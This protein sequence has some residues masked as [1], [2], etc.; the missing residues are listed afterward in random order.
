VTF[1]GRA[2]TTARL[3]YIADIEHDPDAPPGLVEF[4]RA[5][6]FRSIFAAPLLRDGRAIGAIG[7]THRAVEGFTPKQGALLETFADQAVIAI[8]NVRLFTELQEKNSA[9]TQAHAQITET[10]EQQ[11]ATADILRVIASSPTDL[12]PVFKAIIE[13]AT[14][15]CGARVGHLFR[16]D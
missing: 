14:R 11:T 9:L 4:A 16:F 3:L 7:V 1:A 10:L 8:E 5:N 2:V 12:Q 13:S 6:G 15:L